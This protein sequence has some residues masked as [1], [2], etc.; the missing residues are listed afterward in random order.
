AER[1]R[2]RVAE[3]AALVDR[4]R[5]LGGD[6]A[7]DAAGEGELPEQ[8]PQAV[9]VVRDVGVQLPVGAVEIRVR[10]EPRPAVSGAGHVDRI[11]VARADRAVHVRVDEVETGCRA[12]VSEQPRLHVLGQ[13]RLAEQRVVEQVD[14]PDREVVRRA[15]PCVDEAE[16]GVRRRPFGRLDHY[17]LFG[18]WV[19]CGLR[20]RTRASTATQPVGSAITGFRSSSATAGRSSASRARRPSRSRRAASSAAGAPRNPRTSVPALP[21]WTSSSASVSVRGAMAKVVPPISSAAVPPGPKATSGPK[22]GSWTTPASSSAPPEI[23]A[24]TSSGPPIRSAASRT[25]PA[26]ERSSAMPPTSV[27]CAPGAAV[28]STTG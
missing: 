26:V 23:I 19:G 28:F 18:S 20:T 17:Q 9:L 3:L 13:Q 22:T 10:D 1:V 14:L 21:E 2:E 15:P 6:V 25:S 24:C 27:L 11:Q 8:P 16:L 7:R 4:A 5:R 12:E